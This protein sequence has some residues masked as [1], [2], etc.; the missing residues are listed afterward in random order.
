MPKAT[1]Q[2][3]D[4]HVVKILGA[5]DPGEVADVIQRG[6]E[7]RVQHERP[8]EY[9]GADEKWFPVMETIKAGD[10]PR[11][12]WCSRKGLAELED[13]PSEAANFRFAPCG[14]K[15]EVFLTLPDGTYAM[16]RAVC[17]DQDGFWRKAGRELALRRALERLDLIL[18]AREQGDFAQ[19][20]HFEDDEGAHEDAMELRTALISAE[21]RAVAAENRV[22]GP[23][24]LNRAR[25]LMRRPAAAQALF[26]HL[27]P[28]F[29]KKNGPPD[30]TVYDALMA[31]TEAAVEEEANAGGAGTEVEIRVQYETSD[32]AAK[33]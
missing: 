29:K 23:I 10:E 24:P 28:Y 22:K 14:G 20:G 30:A 31:A 33:A 9:R 16:G 4:D 21:N 7:A 26:D 13:R 12:M 3:S 32:P 15:T 1:S 18:A 8:I 2:M 25:A 27:A 11:Q 6:C 17:S 5:V 19:G